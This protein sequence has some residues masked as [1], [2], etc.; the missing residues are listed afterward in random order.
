M[1]DFLER[2]SSGFHRGALIEG[3]DDIS[4]HRSM[5]MYA[6]VRPWDVSVDTEGRFFG[7]D[8]IPPGASATAMS[9]AE[10]ESEL[11]FEL[12]TAAIESMRYCDLQYAGA[13]IG[14]LFQCE[15]PSDCYMNLSHVQV[16]MYITF[17]YLANIT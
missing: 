9:P 10:F 3:S 15:A 11:V 1:M 7:A 2:H 16:R 12:D 5:Q 14:P 8:G 13:N 17:A 4:V 6:C